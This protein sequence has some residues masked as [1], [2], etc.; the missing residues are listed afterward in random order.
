[1]RLAL[2]V[3]GL[4]LPVVT[5]LPHVGK[6][7]AQERDHGISGSVLLP[8]RL[9]CAGREERRKGPVK[10]GR[11]NL[12]SAVLVAR[13]GNL[14]R[15]DVPQHETRTWEA[16]VQ[17]CPGAFPYSTPLGHRE[18]L[19]SG[20]AAVKPSRPLESSLNGY[21]VALTM[22]DKSPACTTR[23]IPTPWLRADV[24]FLKDAT[25]RRMSCEDIAGFVGHSEEE[26]RQKAGSLKLDKH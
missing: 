13:S 4:D 9:L 16:P 5:L 3:R 23:T 7:F 10:L 6:L 24:F 15:F 26:V 19:G 8:G 18:E 2:P 22:S 14:A 12:P 1:M 25:S 17:V 11:V 20:I 21:R